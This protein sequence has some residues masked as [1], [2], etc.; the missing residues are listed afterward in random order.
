MA[1]AWTR[2]TDG[3]RGDWIVSVTY[4][5]PATVSLVKRAIPLE[6]VP[7]FPGD[8]INYTIEATLET[9]TGVSDLSVGDILPAG[10]EYINAFPTPE[11]VTNLPDGRTS[12]IW[13]EE[14]LNSG[15]TQYSVKAK[16]RA[17]AALGEQLN[18]ITHATYGQ[19]STSAFTRHVVSDASVSIT[20]TVSSASSRSCPVKS[21]ITRLHTAT[22][23]RPRSPE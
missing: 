23:V 8:E 9:I 22:R 6:S 1:R 20:K 10:L 12:V 2:W 13:P 7:Q 19:S 11:E 18:N 16:V 14:A 4:N 5:A 15:S 21:L 3:Q 17:F